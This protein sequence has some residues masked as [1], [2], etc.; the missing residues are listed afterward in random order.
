VELLEPRWVPSLTSLASFGG[1]NPYGGL[2]ED[3]KG[4]FFGTTKS[5]GT[6]FDGTVFE[7]AAGSW[8][9]TTIGVFAGSN[10]ANP[11]DTLILDSSGNL[12]GTTYGGGSSVYGTGTVF[13]LPYNAGTGSYGTIST[14][15]SFNLTNGLYPQ[16][17]LVEDRS[18]NLFGTT[19]RGGSSIYGTVFELPY[20]AGT[21]SYGTIRTLAS[22]NLTNGALPWGGLVEDRSGNL[23]GTTEEGGSSD[24]GTVFELPYNAG[25]GRYGAISTLASLNVTN[26]EYPEGGLV[27][28]SSG[29]LFG[30]TAYGGSSDVGT[31]FELPYNAGTG[32]Y[33]TISTL[34]SFNVTNGT[35]P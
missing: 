19:Y 14:L 21:G 15:A 18:G 34:A 5:G 20:S 31:V 13:E 32:G 33:G 17:G 16:A 10:G 7:I 1:G 23:F 24:A 30:S 27:E 4:N 29:N 26:G 2:V 11:Q 6:N 12:F 8:T 3:N 25:T 22:F 28:D 35:F 9:Y